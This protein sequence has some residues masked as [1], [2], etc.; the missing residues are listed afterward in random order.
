MH[1]RALTMQEMYQ[2]TSSSVVPSACVSRLIIC[3]A[4]LLFCG[5]KSLT[6]STMPSIVVRRATQADVP[7][8]TDI[9]FRSFNQK[10]WQHFCPDQPANREFISDMWSRG[11]DAPTDRSFVAVDTD[12]DSKLVGLSRWQVPQ[13]DGSQNHDA[14]PEPSM[15]DQEIAR[16]FFGGMDENRASIMGH[17]PHFCKSISIWRCGSF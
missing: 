3:D 12:Q 2:L 16:P 10:F 11:I 8:M 6:F 7:G 13:A 14:W 1:A 5:P 9:F 4:V 17:K 15:L